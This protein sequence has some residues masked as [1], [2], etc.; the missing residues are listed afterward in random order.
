M[1]FSDRRCLALLLLAFAWISLPAAAQMPIGSGFVAPCGVALD[2]AGNL[3]VADEDSQAIFEIMAAG[4]YVN[5]YAYGVG[6]IGGACGIAVDREGNV[7][8][9]VGNAVKEMTAADGY[10]TI[11]QLATG[12]SGPL[13][14]A[15]D[16]AGNIFVADRYNGA[17]K[18]LTLASGYAEV[19]TLVSGLDDPQGVA[20]DRAGDLFVTDLL[21]NGEVKEFLAVDGTIPASP[22]T[23][24][25][26]GAISSSFGL[27]PFGVVVDPVGN[28]FFTNGFGTPLYEV[29]AAG[30]Y[31]TVKQVTAFGSELT[32][33]AIDGHGNIFYADSGVGTVEEIPASASTLL[34]SVLPGSRS[35]QVGTPATVFATVINTGAAPL[36]TCQI[37]LPLSAPPGLGLS[38]QT[39]DAASNTPVGAPNTPVQIP[40]GNGAQSFIVTFQGTIPFSASA[41]P[42]DFQ[43]EGTAPAMAIAGVDTIDLAVSSTPTADIIALSATP[44]NNGLIA[45]PDGGSAAFAV[46]SVNVGAAAQITVS[47]DTGTAD[48]PV[49]LAIC[50]TDPATAACLAP[51]AA[52]V[53]LA[54]A[55]GAAP[56]FSIFLQATG[57]I[58]F[59]PDASRVFL[60]FKDAGGGV[61]GSTSVAI[62]SP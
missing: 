35:V 50:Q 55:G 38:Y 7:F 60:R 3:F 43:C 48:L 10:A 21:N 19:T 54:Y 52:T 29:L 15:L 34:A 59:A 42:L 39:T 18:E 41:M 33:I 27:D 37:A 44:S 57:P 28:V 14:L 20:V 4:G 31:T 36:D 40:G 17:V 61:H 32:G 13:G 62:E 58:A 46:A 53:S 30:G 47:A 5:V 2:P 1:N 51:P 16:S 25:I 22:Q 24:K 12:F 45:V 49:N 26:S 6:Q 9:A 11:K 23:V 8:V 56:T